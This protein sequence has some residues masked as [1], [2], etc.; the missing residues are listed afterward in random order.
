RAT[1]FAA[2]PGREAP[3]ASVEKL[4]T[5]TAL[6]TLLGPEAHLDTTLLGLGSLGPGGIWHGS[7]YLR[8][9]G[10][11]T[12]GSSAF[13]SSHYG[14]G[15]SLDELAEA[16]SKR[17]IHTVEGQVLGD[18]SFLDSRRGDPSSG[19]APDGEL[20]GNLSGLAFN[21]GQTGSKRGPHAPAL[22][23][24]L[25]L[26]RALRARHISVAHGVGAASAPAGAQVLAEIRSPPLS[27]LLGLMDRPSD[28]FFAE[29]LLKDLGALRGSGGSTAAGAA[30]VRGVLAP[31]GL[32]PRILDGS[33]LS[34]SDRTSPLAVVT[35]LDD[36]AHTPIGAVL[37]GDLAVPGRSGTLALRMRGTPAAGRCQA[38]TGT[39]DFVSN[40]AGYCHAANGHLIAF[41]LFDDRI[42]AETAHHLQDTIA[43][44]L[45]A[46]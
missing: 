16:L 19:F 39:L 35:L 7:L 33:G 3:P 42:P 37:A 22:Y 8:G 38:K 43:A 46:Y 4:Y 34:H 12:F 21:R 30:L 40:L 5:S 2:N 18:E 44:D 10:D 26:L 6:L 24:A 32:H 45:A 41:A 14:S 20:E 9:G 28:N 11:P 15:A 27:T 25:E 23:A 31:L 36:L 13:I 1:L 29:T 17:G